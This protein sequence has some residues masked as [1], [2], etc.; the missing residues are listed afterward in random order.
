MKSYVIISFAASRSIIWDEL[1]AEVTHDL[2]AGASLARRP[3]FAGSS[4][5]P[6]AALSQA[7]QR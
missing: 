7:W 6:L 2:S 5:P 3:Q 4:R 1:L